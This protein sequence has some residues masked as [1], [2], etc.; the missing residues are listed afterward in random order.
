MKGLSIFFLGLLV[1]FYS[2]KPDVVSISPTEQFAIDLEKIDKYLAE[3]GIKDT[4]IHRDSQIRYIIEET[5]TGISP[6]FGSEDSI[7]VDYKG[8]IL[9]SGEEF[10]SGTSASFKLSTTIR[11]W[12]IML[13]EMREGDAFTIYL[14]SIY[15]YGTKGQGPIPPNAVIVFYIKLL[16][17]SS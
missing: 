1:V 15:G 2:C 6:R 16:R 4:L 14:P 13:P 8:W 9:E 5:G 11:G 3:N 7:L 12:Q 17:V 10:D